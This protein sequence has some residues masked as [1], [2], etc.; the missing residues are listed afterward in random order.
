MEVSNRE[1]PFLLRLKGLQPHS[2]YWYESARRRRIRIVVMAGPVGFEPAILGCPN[3]R[4]ECSDG[5]SLVLA[6]NGPY[7]TVRVL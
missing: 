5:S 3:A 2:Q 6:R 4:T 1:R 7:R